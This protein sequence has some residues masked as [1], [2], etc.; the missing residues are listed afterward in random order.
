M[1]CTARTQAQLCWIIQYVGHQ[2]TELP[3]S[4][5]SAADGWHIRHSLPK[6][7]SATKWLASI[8]VA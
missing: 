1:S 2:V 6:V 3:T 5:L 7:R 8:R 4:I